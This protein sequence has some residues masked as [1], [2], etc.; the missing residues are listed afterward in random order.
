MRFSHKDIYSPNGISKDDT[1]DLTSKVNLLLKEIKAWEHILDLWC[2]NALM[3][4][5]LSRNIKWWIIPY[6]IDAVK[7]HIQQAKYI[8]RLDFQ[9]NFI[10]GDIL[11]FPF[12]D[13]DNFDMVIF[14]PGTI[15]EEYLGTFF[16]KLKE[17]SKKICILMYTDPVS[18]K[19]IRTRNKLKSFLFKE[20]WF[21]WKR[22]I[23]M[24]Y[25][26]V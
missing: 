13:Y 19:R 24:V 10:C 9:D 14:D 26:I 2:W 16:T 23:D 8:F 11:D 22:K 15:G 1:W 25:T 3:L 18:K 7:S 4:Q 12:S 20:H 17:R 5:V 21:I 6:W